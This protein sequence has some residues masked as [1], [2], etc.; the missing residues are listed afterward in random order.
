MDEDEIL[1][2]RAIHNAFSTQDGKIALMWILY[3]C[4][5]FET[6]KELVDPSLVAFAGRLLKA[7]GMIRRINVPAFAES[8]LSSYTEI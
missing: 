1:Q 8:I 6:N 4:G 5:F 3:E 2:Q 7:G